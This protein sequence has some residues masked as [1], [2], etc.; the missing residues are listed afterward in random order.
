[1]E[2]IFSPGCT[3][4][5]PPTHAPRL[6]CVHKHLKSLFFSPLISSFSLSLLNKTLPLPSALKLGHQLREKLEIMLIRIC[7]ANR[8]GK[9]T[10]SAKDG[11]VRL[12]FTSD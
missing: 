10:R 5:V 3:L 4:K 12:L 9:E 7:G 2:E 1:M 11:K 6:A 8:A